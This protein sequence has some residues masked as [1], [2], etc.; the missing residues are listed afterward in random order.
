MVPN[1]VLFKDRFHCSCNKSRCQ[2]GVKKKTQLRHRGYNLYKN[3]RMLALWDESHTS[4][5]LRTV[6]IRVFGIS[7]I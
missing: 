4:V 5:A 7:R 1:E 6:R 3:G 2:R